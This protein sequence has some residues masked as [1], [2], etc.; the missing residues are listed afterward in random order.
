[1]GGVF[2]GGGR[3]GGGGGGWGQKG[4]NRGLIGWNKI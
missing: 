3:A 2:E 4:G 1:M